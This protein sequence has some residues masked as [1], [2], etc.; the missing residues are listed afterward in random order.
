MD[1]ALNLELLTAALGNHARLPSPVA[2][3]ALLSSAEVGLFTRSREFDRSMLDAAWYL[4]A[5]ATAR[6]DLQLYGVIRQRQAHRVSAHIFDLALQTNDL[7]REERLRLTVAAQVGYLGGE[8]TPN[9]SA[10]ARRVEVSRAPA[11]LDS[12][13]TVS[14]EAAVLLLALDRPALYP[15]LRVRET[16]L[17]ASAAEFGPVTEAQYSV[18][19]RVIR[20]VRAMTNFLTYGQTTHLERSR[21]LLREA[22]ESQTAREDTDSRW[23][24][25]H[26]L[27]LADGLESS[28]VW[29]ILPPDL[30]SAARA[31]TLGDPPVMQLWPPQLAFLATEGP[32]EPSPLSAE[33]RRVILSFP[34]S[35][36]KS[37]L[38]QLF[39]T[40]H[41]VGGVGNVCIVAPTHSL[42]RELSTALGRRLRTLG[43]QLFLEPDL[44]FDVPKPPAVR[45]VV[46]TPEK[47]AARLRSDPSGL[48]QEFG[49]FIIDEAHLV[50]DLER[51]WRL[52]ETLS[53]LNHLTE[54]THHRLIV[55]S[56]ALGS[57]A[58]VVAWLDAGAGV[59]ARHED[60]RG[61]RRLSAI[62][63]TE[64][65]WDATVDE[66]AVG[67]RLARRAT[68]LLGVLHLR[69]GAAGAYTRGVFREPVG[70]LVLRENREGRRVRDTTRSTT[71]RAQLVPLIRHL[72]SAGPVLVVEATKN[73]AQRLAQ[74]IAEDLEEEPLAFALLDLVRL[75][76]GA[77]HPLTGVLRKGI[78]FHHAA[79]PVDI[80]AEIEEE[81][82][83][84]HITCLVATTTLTEGVNLPFKS[85]L[86]A[87][88]GY[89]DGD[90][91]VEIIDAPRLLN[92]VGRAGRAGRETEGW[93]ILA[94]QQ[95]FQ[96]ALFD[97]LDRTGSDLD[98][99]ST[100]VSQR[101]LEQLAS[102]EEAA[103]ADADAIFTSVG[104]E[105]D[106][107][108]SYIWLVS[109]ALTEMGVEPTLDAVGQAL[110]ATLA[111]QQ[112]DDAG[113]TRFV[114][115]GTRAFGAFIARSSEQRRRWA[116]SGLSLPSAAA[117]ETVAAEIHSLV[118]E[119]MVEREP[120]RVVEA[121]LADGRLASVLALS[122]N[123]R[124]G[125]KARRN[126][127]RN[128][129]LP[130]DLLAL[131]TDWVAGA[132]LQDLA[133]RHLAAVTTDDYRYQQLA[134]FIA[135]VFEHFLP[136][137]MNTIIAWV[138]ESLES[139]GVDLKIP[140]DLPATI[141]Y[142]VASRNGL[143]LMLGGIRSR[144]LANRI[145]TRRA[146]A[147]DEEADLSMRDWLAG[148]DISQWRENF[149]ASPTEV[150]DLL[151]FV[152]DPAI[153]IVYQVLDGEQYALQF[154]ARGEVN[155]DSAAELGQEEGQPEPAPMVIIVE[156][157]VVGD[158]SPDYHDELALLTGIGIPLD[159][160][161]EQSAEGPRLTLRL[162]VEPDA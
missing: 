66:P 143:T 61:P 97:P 152:R 72:R 146:E 76:L 150:T 94:E 32:D 75:R 80:Q 124:N 37:L 111:W 26:L 121:M 101:A 64:P 2:L 135:S 96:P 82:R 79:L 35:A 131:L 129:L 46:M 14:L 15:L 78:A 117:L 132:E 134:E 50:A 154:V 5:I 91:F 109:Q 141:H 158:V 113:R 145:S 153:Q 99:R 138:N 58:H 16:Q 88:R 92:A 8:L 157:E 98:M 49:M 13:G 69:T 87:Q 48:L 57:Q 28:S 1:R 25:A 95:D 81:V 86:V 151:A 120:A 43:Q 11:A 23:V 105:A 21:A 20:G 59:L 67:T 142:G 4:Q 17:A 38:A 123:H 47:L 128:Q 115:V 31:M 100:L 12:P 83:R 126:D 104:A 33:V 70:E 24:A 147:V 139:D 85:V 137:A 62:Y 108:I 84:G 74:E 148:Q 29:A 155:A 53:L 10:I 27:R 40:T 130:V 45:A 55:L 42:C 39:V 90:E 77:E 73:E 9:A 30:A 107:F 122:E 19:E 6:E 140:E 44:Y 54:D 63:T 36:G 133:E 7:D 60:W 56:A 119:A 68:P 161:V 159:I 52:E 125:F 51:G 110:R 3:Q 71:M 106:G 162:A 136:W 127:P 65:D 144:R 34:T 116:R 156:G 93:L 89:Q 102:L 160:R 112:L 149:E 103:Q 41:L 114:N 22:L 118:S 18:A